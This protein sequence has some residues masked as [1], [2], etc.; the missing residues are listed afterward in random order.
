MAAVAKHD[1]GAAAPRHGADEAVRDPADT[2]DTASFDT[3]VDTGEPCGLAE[4]SVFI[5]DAL[6]SCEEGVLSLDVV[7]ANSGD[8]SVPAGIDISVY[9]LPDMVLLANTATSA[10]LAAGA[11]GSVIEIDIAIDDIGSEGLVVVVDG[12][13]QVVEHDIWP[14]EATWDH[15]CCD[16]DSLGELWGVATAWNGEVLALD[17]TLAAAGQRP[18]GVVWRLDLDTQQAHVVQVFDPSDDEIFYLGTL[19]LHPTEPI[20]YVSAYHYPSSVTAYD[21][22]QWLDG[23]DTLIAIDTDTYAVLDTWDL[24]PDPYSFTGLSSDYVDG[25]TGLYSPGDLFFVD[26]ELYTFEGGTVE[27]SDLVHIDLSGSTPVL[28]ELGPTFDDGFW[29]AET[30]TDS[31]GDHFTICDDVPDPNY[32]GNGTEIAFLSTPSPFAPYDPAAV[33]SCEN[34]LF[35]FELDRVHGL[36]MSGD[37]TLYA[38]R[39]SRGYWYD[40]AAVQATDLQIYT[41]DDNGLMDPLVDLSG[42]FGSQTAPIDGIGGMDWRAKN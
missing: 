42:L 8:V 1:D 33:N 20:A 30:V 18:G 7:V 4:L 31:A 9:S 26:G 24:D 36:A 13:D 38:G 15:L 19:A 5:T 10:G 32:D 3:G 27:H 16:E 35:T 37:D 6:E 12:D 25:Q 28:T 11:Y 17:G 2:S 34:P 22:D 23:V 29:G 40:Q 14:N 21:S 41:V 39:T